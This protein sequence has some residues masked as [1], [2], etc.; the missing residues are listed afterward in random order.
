MHSKCLLPNC[1]QRKK[2]RSALSPG[3]GG[4]RTCHPHRRRIGG[5]RFLRQDNKKR[6]RR[7][8]AAP[9]SPGGNLRRNDFLRRGDLPRGYILRVDGFY[10]YLGLVGIGGPRRNGGF[11]S[12]DRFHLSAPVFG[13]RRRGASLPGSLHG[14][15]DGFK[16]FGFRRGGRW[17]FLDLPGFFGGCR[18]RKRRR[19]LRSW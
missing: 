18:R 7:L 14:I 13:L 15:L 8:P 1:W 4:R 5:A 12:L 17:G 9:S 10:R 6:G 11:R 19:C 2:S 16:G 3:E